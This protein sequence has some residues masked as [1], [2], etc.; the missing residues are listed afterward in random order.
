MKKQY[1]IVLAAILAGGTLCASGVLAAQEE[2]TARGYGATSGQTQQQQDLEKQRQTPGQQLGQQGEFKTLD[3]LS[4]MQ[5][6]NQQGQ[7]LGSIDQVLIDMNQGRLAFVVVNGGVAAAEGEKYIVPW[8][9]VRTSPQQ[10]GLIL[11]VS[12]L[13]QLRP[14]AST[15]QLEETLT[16]Q[17]GREIFQFYGISPYWEE[18]G[19]QMQQDQ[20]QQMPQDQMHQQM[21]EQMRQQRQQQMPQTPQ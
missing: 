17:S 20:M 4:G 18:S 11:N 8:Q 1:A 7:Q 13:D 16:R 5:I 3:S 21:M 10:E 19:Q 14:V 12:S 6:Q 9:M 2:Q 15:E